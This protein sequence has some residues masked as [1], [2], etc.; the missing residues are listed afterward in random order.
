MPCSS[1]RV[2][3]WRRGL[4]TA[5][6]AALVLAPAPVLAQP[7]PAAAPI[8]ERLSAAA[9]EGPG[10][11]LSALS[12][13]LA[14]QPQLAATPASAAALAR[15]AADP[16]ASFVGARTPVYRDIARRI[17]AAA[18]TATRVTVREAVNEALGSYLGLEMRIA[19]VMRPGLPGAP[20]PQP[21]Q[22]GAHGYTLGSFTIYPDVQAAT[23]YDDNIYATS[24]DHVSDWVGSISPR[25]AIQ[26]KW[27][28]NS[29]YAEAQ[30]D[31]TGYWSH[32]HENTV[33]WHVLG[34]GQ[35]DVT[36]KTRVLLG[37]IALQSHEDRASPEVVEGFVPTP[38]DEQNAYAGVEHRFDLIHTAPRRRRRT[39]H[40]R[41]CR[42]VARGDQQ[43]GPQPGPLHVR[44][45][46]A[47]RGQSEPAP[48]RAGHGRHP[49]LRYGARRFRLQSQLER[50][51]CRRRHAVPADAQTDR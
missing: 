48:L 23:F 21:A 49:A 20:A 38:Y 51:H 2:S 7:V 36:S 11:L 8:A 43:P 12:Q 1:D 46:V 5:A 40:V 34:E 13:A 44:R 22:A 14:Q 16:V 26:S 27:D 17:I 6:L 29:L 50:V 28:R 10:A 9:V 33:D 30:A 37:A 41:Q 4:R 47:L 31:F 19:P 25:I 32:P 45:P 35:I 15:A 3:S 42:G 18:P 39:H 24:H